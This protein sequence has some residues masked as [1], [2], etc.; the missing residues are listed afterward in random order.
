MGPH[1][2]LWGPIG[3]YGT[4]WDPVGPYG[5]LSDPYGTLW[6]PIF[7]KN[8]PRG[9]G[10]PAAG[11]FFFQEMAPLNKKKGPWRWQSCRRRFFSPGND[12]FKN[13]MGLPLVF[14]GL[15]PKF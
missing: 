14:W 6:N 2:A 9:A 10:S 12:T 7:K 3:P 5:T 15:Q 4:L 13:K 8:V 11:A 1:V